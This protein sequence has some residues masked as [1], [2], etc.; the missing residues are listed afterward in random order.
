MDGSELAELID[1]RWRK[2]RQLLEFGRRQMDAIQAARMSEL[3][4]LLS[5]KQA[6]LTELTELAEQIRAAKDDDPAARSWE[7][8]AQRDRCRSQQDECEQMHMDLL[9]LEAECETALQQSRVTIQQRLDRVDA[10]RVAANRYADQ[11]SRQTRGGQ[12]DLS[13]Q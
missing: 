12:L 4:Q 11:G 6:P 2:L 3:M 8:E 10:G 7:S 1:R 5:D 13:S 9:A